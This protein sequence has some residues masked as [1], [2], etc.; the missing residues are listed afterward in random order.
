MHKKWVEDNGKHVLYFS[1][2]YEF[3]E[4]VAEVFH[5]DDGGWCYSSKLLNADSEYLGSDTLE[6]AKDDVESLIESHYES[7]V[8][9]YQELLNK[10]KE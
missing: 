2:F 6:D 7:E 10:F 8:N 9:Y 3:E 4:K 1:P 5:E